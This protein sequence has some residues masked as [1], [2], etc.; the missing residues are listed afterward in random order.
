VASILHEVN[1]WISIGVGG[2]EEGLVAVT[3]EA[4]ENVSGAGH[5]AAGAGI[6]IVIVRCA[7]FGIETIATWIVY[8]LA[9]AAVA[10]A[11]GVV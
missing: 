11:C 2:H 5:V 10:N 8:K 3:V 4:V 7:V 9:L 6:V 1:G